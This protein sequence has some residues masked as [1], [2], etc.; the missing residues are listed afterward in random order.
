MRLSMEEFDWPFFALKND[1]PRQLRQWSGHLGRF[2][3]ATLV[4]RTGSSPQPVGCQMLVGEDGHLAGYVSGGCVESNLA[5]IAQEVIETGQGRFVAFGD[6]SP[7]ID[8]RLPCGTRIELAL[9]R[10]EENDPAIR[11]IAA[12]SRD[13]TPALY[14]S[15]IELGDRLCV[16]LT[17]GVPDMEGEG[18]HLLRTIFQG[19][20]AAELPEA[21][22][23]GQIY[24]KRYTPTPRLVINGGDPVAVALALMAQVAGFEVIVNRRD[25]PAGGIDHPEIRYCRLGGDALFA[26]LPPDRWTAMV[27]TTHDIE[28]DHDVL[29]RALPSPAFYVG[30]LGSRS[31]LPERLAKLRQAGIELPN[32]ARLSA[33]VGMDIGA[34]GPNEIAVSILGDVIRAWRGK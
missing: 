3:I 20:T 14:A 30:V 32:I 1:I 15:D 34:V 25:G 26:E 2:V 28:A 8:V 24:W 11:D 7:Y 9:E 22:Q 27:S 18:G 17:N 10:F 29:A 6:D 33:P 19:R 5:V 21:G 23:I 16:A 13:R 12:L 4:S 31:H